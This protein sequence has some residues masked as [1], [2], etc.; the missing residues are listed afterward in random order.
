MIVYSNSVLII[1]AHSLL[2]TSSAD[3]RGWCSLTPSLPSHMDSPSVSK[4]NVSSPLSA[5]TPALR[6]TRVR[7]ACMGDVMER[8]SEAERMC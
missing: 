8:I 6:G 2:V 5:F 4:H 7:C 3:K 1:D